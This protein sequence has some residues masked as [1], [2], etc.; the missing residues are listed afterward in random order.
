MVGQIG[1][2][3]NVINVIEEENSLRKS[4]KVYNEYW[5]GIIEVN[6]EVSMNNLVKELCDYLYLL[7]Q[8]PI[9][10]GHITGGILSKPNYNA[11]DVIAEADDSY[12]ECIE[13]CIREAITGYLEHEGWSDRE[14]L[15]TI[16]TYVN[17][18]R[19]YK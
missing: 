3:N 17:E 7:E 10:Y 9:V 12:A 14:K 5:K 6:G 2:R 19:E 13:G 1:G 18:L 8:V 4:W 16:R 11:H 15:D